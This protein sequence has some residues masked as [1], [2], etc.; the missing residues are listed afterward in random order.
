MPNASSTH[1]LNPLHWTFRQKFLAAFLLC[2]A[3]LLVSLHVQFG[4]GVEPCSMCTLQRGAFM[5]LCPPL[6][7]GA[8]HAPRGRLGRGIYS[9]IVTLICAS[10]GAVAARQVWLQS[11]PP[12]KVPACGPDLA[13]MLKAWPLTQMLKQVLSGS[14]DCAEIDWSLFGLSMAV[15]AL[16]LFIAF[17]LWCNV[18]AYVKNRA[19]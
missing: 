9:G 7:I 5:L 2:V 15:W 11:L 14:G 16:M 17:T 18:A 4:A 8:L 13:Y 19:S 6:L 10:G 12:E 3:V 1:W